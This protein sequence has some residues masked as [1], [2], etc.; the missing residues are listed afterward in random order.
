MCLSA[1]GGGGDVFRGGCYEISL[2]PCLGFCKVSFRLLLGSDHGA[3]GL[4]FSFGG[5]VGL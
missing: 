3:L 4:S 1:V 2:M 5:C